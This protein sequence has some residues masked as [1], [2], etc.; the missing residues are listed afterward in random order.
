MASGEGLIMEKIQNQRDDL[1]LNVILG[2]RCNMRHNFCYQDDFSKAMLSEE[3]LYEKLVPAY[4]KATHITLIG[5]EI[6]TFKG[7]FQYIPYVRSQNKNATISIVT[8]GLVF[9]ESWI[10]LCE[11]ND[12]LVSYSLDATNEKIAATLIDHGK[13]PYERIW[14]NFLK[15]YQRHLK[16][17]SP[18]INCISMVVTPTTICD[19]AAFISLALNKGLNVQI[20]YSHN[21]KVEYN[22]R[23]R[24]SVY[25]TM[26]LK[27]FC[28]DF[29]DVRVLNFQNEFYSLPAIYD[30]VKSPSFA[31]DKEEFLK[32][33]NPIKSRNRYSEWQCYSFDPDVS[34]CLMPW[35]GFNIM[36]NGDVYPC[37]VLW[38]YPIGNIYF[39]TL[40]EI[41]ESQTAQ[42]LRDCLANDDY[43]YCWKRC[44][45]NLNQSSSIDGIVGG[46]WTELNQLFDDHNYEAFLNKCPSL[47]GDRHLP[48]ELVYKK[49]FSQHQLCLYQDAVTS[50]DTAL[51]KGFS[52]FWIR[53]NRGAVL[54]ELGQKKEALIDM[55]QAVTLNPSHEGAKYLHQQ[56][57]AAC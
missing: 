15:L 27:W 29:I 35:K 26:K 37:V 24:R 13:Y 57:S 54:W 51:A 19:I 20:L 52:E 32:A 28:E 5:G 3:V 43:R 8:N 18:L 36:P 41:A 45:S 50:Y 23:I 56:F 53:Y 42:H 49:A 21:D 34:V 14:N 38:N 22:D 9:D 4:K 30:V 39:Q 16:S 48:A 31:K 55:Q 11:E 1:A 2:L 46:Y 7:M 33:N 40:D 44:R 25:Q 12:I 47:D 10:D 6:T 17:R